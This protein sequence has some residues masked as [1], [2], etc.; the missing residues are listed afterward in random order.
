MRAM[1]G[2]T[3]V[4]GG[5][6]PSP[7]IGVPTQT[8]F[9]ALTYPAAQAISSFRS[10]GCPS[11]PKFHLLQESFPLPRTSLIVPAELIDAAESNDAV[12]IQRSHAIFIP[13]RLGFA[14]Q[15]V[16]LCLRLSKIGSRLGEIAH[17][18]RHAMLGAIG[19]RL[20]FLLRARLVL[21]RA[22][23]VDDLA[24]DIAFLKA[25]RSMMRAV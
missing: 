6:P 13:A 10:L 8:A 23:Q 17:R 3:D 20:A 25:G 11:L 15:L 22:A 2:P 18:L 16:R 24:Q 5:T 12:T 7:W 9:H 14:I 1:I 21:T 19:V 4:T